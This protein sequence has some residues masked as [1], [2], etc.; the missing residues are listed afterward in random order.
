MPQGNKHVLGLREGS[1]E[2]T[3]VV[4]SLLADLIDRG[5]DAERMRLW[6]I[7][8]GKALRKAIVEMLRRDARSSSAARST[9][10]ATSSST[11]P[12]TL[13]ASVNRALRDAWGGADA[14][15]AKKQ[16]QRL[17]SL[18]AEPSIPARRPACARGWRRR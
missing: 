7:D 5:L 3:R 6:V 13:H 10:G 1:T 17:A 9:S 11:C 14:T 2:T 16:L 12:R 15:L 8:G 18:A 4:R